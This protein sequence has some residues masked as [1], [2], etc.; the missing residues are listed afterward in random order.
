MRIAV[1]RVIPEAG[2]DLLRQAGDVA[3]WEGELPPSREELVRLA[4]GADGLLTLLTERVDGDLLDRLPSVRVVSNMAVGFDN[5]DVAACT[6]RGVAVC[7]TPDVL[8]ETTADLAFGLLLAVARRIPEGH[9][10]VLAGAWRTWEPMGYLGPDVHGATLGIIGL[11]RIGQ[12]VAR[13]A[14]GFDMR[15]LY[16][17]PRRRPEV[18]EEL[19]AEWRELDALLAESDFVS[20]HVPLTEQTRGM[21]GREQLQRMRRGAVLINTARG[22]VVQTDALL[23]ALEQGWIWAAGLDVTDPEPLPAEHPLLRHPRVVVTP[24][25]AS[26]SFTTR[27]RMAELA[28][29]NLLAVLRGET[30]PRCLNPEVLNRD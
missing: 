13:R 29:R 8:T 20:L 5:I 2:L 10:A 30:P 16:H 17:A 9:N 27:N 15:I 3:V 18:E 21:I 7:T 12:A 11:G 22:P 28:A 6:A 4:E 23:E 19:G 24:H 14:R 26:A 25:I 1:S